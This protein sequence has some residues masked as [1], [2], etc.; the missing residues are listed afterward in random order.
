MLG[1]IGCAWYTYVYFPG[2]GEN[3]LPQQHC[4]S[5]WAR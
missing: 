3:G 5:P 2:R 1:E 4:S